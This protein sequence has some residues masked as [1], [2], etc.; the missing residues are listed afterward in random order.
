MT[1]ETFNKMFVTAMTTFRSELQDNDASQYSEEAREWARKNGLIAGGSS[2]E[3]NGMWEDLMTRE[4][5]VA[6]MYRFAKLMGK[7]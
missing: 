6:V 7:A 1:Q 4:Q 2:D 3:F 5:F